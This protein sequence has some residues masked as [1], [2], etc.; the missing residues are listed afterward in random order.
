MNTDAH[1]AK[2]LHD[3]NIHS[4]HHPFQQTAQGWQLTR[5]QV[6]RLHVD[7]QAPTRSHQSD[8]GLDIYAAEAGEIAPQHSKLVGTG[9]AVAI[10]DGFFGMIADRSSMAKK[11][12]KTAGGIID[13]QY[14]GE[15]KIM[16]WNISN[17]PLKFE[18]G[19]RIAQMIL[20]PCALPRVDVVET[21]SETTRG[22]GGF[23][24][25]GV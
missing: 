22:I 7:A 3:N 6:Q 24:S 20:L 19:D 18:R 12:F 2:N 14:R 15:V 10:P 11:G 4:D 13:A 25:S 17:A 5:L 23:G 9:I 8:A 1:S 16:L 21:L